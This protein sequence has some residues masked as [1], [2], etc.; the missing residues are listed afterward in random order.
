MSSLVHRFLTGTRRALTWDARP[1]SAE[2]EAAA[3]RLVYR[4]R[5][6]PKLPSSTV[7]SDISRM[8]S[9]MSN[10]PVNRRWIMNNSRLQ[11]REVDDFLHRLVEQNAVEVTDTTH[12][13]PEPS[14]T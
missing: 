5:S 14:T 12:Y 7:S 13:S 9:I 3:D 10:R 1:G 6:W 4:L 11:S 2:P 8:L